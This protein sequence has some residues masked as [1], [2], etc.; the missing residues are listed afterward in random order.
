[1]LITGWIT[2]GIICVIKGISM[3]K[4]G[5]SNRPD[6]SQT[7]HWI[8]YAFHELTLAALLFAHFYIYEFFYFAGATPCLSIANFKGL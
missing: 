5:V 2:M 6:K 1:L 7:R 4:G 8:T 3:W